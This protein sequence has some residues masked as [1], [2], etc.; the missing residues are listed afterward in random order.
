MICERLS[1]ARIR[2][3]QSCKVNRVFKRIYFLFKG[4]ELI[5]NK[6]TA[7]T[8]GGGVSCLISDDVTADNAGKYEVSVENKLGKDRRCF[9]VAVE[10]TYNEIYTSKRIISQRVVIKSC[11]KPNRSDSRRNYIGIT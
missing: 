10:G 5:P 3:S 7:I 4:R 8:Y 1:V 2:C 6:K 11:I 9:S